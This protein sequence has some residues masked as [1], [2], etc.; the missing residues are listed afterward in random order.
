[1]DLAAAATVNVELDAGTAAP[2]STPAADWLAALRD[3]V[4]AKGRAGALWQQ[5][6]LLMNRW[7]IA[8]QA[9]A[10]AI[11]GNYIF[12]HDQI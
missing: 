4:G 8:F 6:G 11:L 12:V 3:C 2:T 1:M 5:L 7:M 9:R 10:V